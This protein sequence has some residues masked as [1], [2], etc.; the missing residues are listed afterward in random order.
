[1]VNSRNKG[2]AFERV[3]VNKLNTVLESKGIDTRVKRNLDQYQTK[4]M[5]DIY[6]DNFAIECK[7][8]KESAKKTTYRN[9]WWNQAVESAGDNLIPLLIYKYDRRQIMCVI[10]LCLVTTVKEPNWECTYNCPLS[11]ICENLDEILQKANGLK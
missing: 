10:P 4:G 7:R 3:I 8:Y 11:E 2:A 6:F 1:M 5:A 9:E